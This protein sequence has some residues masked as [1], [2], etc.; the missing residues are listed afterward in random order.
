MADK[1]TQTSQNGI[2]WQAQP[3]PAQKRRAL[4][5][6]IA[7]AI[8]EGDAESREA[9]AAIISRVLSDRSASERDLIAT[10]TD[11][12]DFLGE[13]RPGSMR[14]IICQRLRAAIAAWEKA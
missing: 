10:A 14:A 7:D 11:A 1:I 9:D 2:D 6:R 5:E 8:W 12:A 3:D 13:V 4:A